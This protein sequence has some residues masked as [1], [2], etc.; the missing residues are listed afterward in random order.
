MAFWKFVLAMVLSFLPGVLGIFF[1]PIQS[2]QDA[3][4]ATLNNSA[5]TPDGWV[6]SVVWTILYFL[7]GLALFLVMR[8]VQTKN[9]HDKAGAYTAFGINIV[10]NFL[11]TFI[12]FGTRLPE[13]A[14]IVL[15]ALIITAIFMARAFFRISKV[16]FWLVVPYIIWLMF[17]FYL[18]AMIICLN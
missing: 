4:Y 11:W 8:H 10:L 2:G 16:S 7:I 17:A 9:N 13:A 12:F 18:N 5:L 6:F 15:T 14:L 3:W 1:S